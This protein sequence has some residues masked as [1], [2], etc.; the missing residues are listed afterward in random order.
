[1]T[2][3]WKQVE[4]HHTYD[5]YIKVSIAWAPVKGLRIGLRI[6]E[7]GKVVKI[8]QNVTCWKCACQRLHYRDI[9]VCADCGIKNK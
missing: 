1:M 2:E 4:I 7:D 6:N 5:D 3:K 8:Y 9:R